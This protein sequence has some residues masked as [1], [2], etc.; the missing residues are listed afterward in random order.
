MS[1][2][3]PEFEMIGDADAD[4]A[5]CVDGMCAVPGVE[6]DAEGQAED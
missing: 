6:T 4:A 5:V 3:L 2:P 1:E